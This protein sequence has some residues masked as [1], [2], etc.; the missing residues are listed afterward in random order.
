MNENTK[1][2][3][4]SR[5]VLTGAATALAGLAGMISGQISYVDGIQLV[6]TGLIGVFLRVQKG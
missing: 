5:T 2:W 6:S 1:P 3:F 4:K